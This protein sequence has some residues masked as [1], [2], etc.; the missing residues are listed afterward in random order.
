MPLGPLGMG[1]WGDVEVSMPAGEVFPDAAAV[2]RWL[3]KDGLSPDFIADHPLRHIHRRL[4]ATDVYFVANGSQESLTTLCSFRV[5][6]N[7]PELW[8][9]ETGQITALP[10]Y[11][12]KHGR[13]HVPL[14][15]GP[16]ESV[17]I[18]F[19]H[20]GEAAR[21]V[22]SVTRDGEEVL[23][24][25]RT[26][27]L[28]R[29]RPAV[30]LVRGEICR[31]GVYAIRLANGESRE[32]RCDRLPPL[33][34]A[35]P[36]NVSFDPKWGGP[37]SVTFTKL[38]DWSKRPEDGIKYYS[39]TATYRTTFRVDDEALKDPDTRWRLDLGSVAVMAEVKLNG[40]DLGILWKPPY[41]VDVTEAL[42]PGENTL[43]VKVVNLWI[44]RQIG[45][46][47]LPDDSPRTF[48]GAEWAPGGAN[49][50][51]WPQW[52]LDGKPSP[53]GRYTFTSWR[54]WKKNDPL[55]TS[56]LLGPVRLEAA[57]AMKLA[58]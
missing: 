47:Q 43:E 52:L 58:P 40:H 46:E 7:Q 4:G 26:A 20:P 36:W 13:T 41:R 9:P 34:I 25:A 44:N 1:P 21:H 28:D 49:L 5:V 23:R 48:K 14:R 8:H 29:D 55:V 54:L 10:A 27:T 51:A 19:R 11:D 17:F 24:A 22:V 2:H 30:D 31:P 53:T 6:G 15:F 45:D 33:E 37:A 18:V 39:G 16:A 50:K 42:K 57:K 32:I 35:S 3:A 12:V 38:D 56:G